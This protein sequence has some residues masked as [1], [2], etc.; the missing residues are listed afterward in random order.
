MA[1]HFHAMNGEPGYMPDNNSVLDSYEDA[2][3]SLRELFREQLCGFHEEEFFT[4]LADGRDGL[5]A[6]HR[7]SKAHEYPNQKWCHAG[8]GI[9]EI[10]ACDDPDCREEE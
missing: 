1:T 2:E 8:A 3:N 10:I 4:A 6:Y 9:A 5:S 7:F